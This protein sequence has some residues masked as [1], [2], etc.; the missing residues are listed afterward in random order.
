MVGRLDP[1][2]FAQVV[3]AHDEQERDPASVLCTACVDVIGVG[4]NQYRPSIRGQRGQRILLLEDGCSEF[5][6]IE[7]LGQIRFPTG[8]IKAK[9]EEIRQVLEREGLL[10]GR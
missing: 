6:N 4:P 7:G 2:R 3:A 1:G 9:S 10:P 8:N 5:T